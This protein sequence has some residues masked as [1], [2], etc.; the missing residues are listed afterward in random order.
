MGA[1]G[2][3]GFRDHGWRLVR[4]RH[5]PGTLRAGGSGA[6][7]VPGAETTTLATDR[8]GRPRRAGGDLGRPAVRRTVLASVG[9]DRR[10]GTRPG[11]QRSRFHVH[12][13]HHAAGPPK[14]G[15]RRTLLATYRPVPSTGRVRHRGSGRNRAGRR[16]VGTGG[17]RR[18]EA[19][20]F[21]I[22]RRTLADGRFGGTA[23]AP[24]GRVV[25]GRGG[26]GAARSERTAAAAGPG[27]TDAADRGGAARAVVRYV[28]AVA[29]GRGGTGR[30][31]R[32]RRY[33][34][35]SGGRRRVGACLR[36]GHMA[37]FR[38]NG[39]AYERSSARRTGV[40]ARRV[41]GTA[42]RTD[43]RAARTVR[44]RATVA[45]GP[46]AGPGVGTARGRTA[47]AGRTA[48]AA[49]FEATPRGFG[50]TVQVRK[51][52]DGRQ[53]EVEGVD[54]GLP[55]AAGPPLAATAE[56]TDRTG[57]GA[58]SDV[59]GLT[60]VE[61][62]VHGHGAG[63]AGARAEDGLADQGTA[64][65]RDERPAQAEGGAAD[66]T[67]DG[68]ALDGGDRVLHAPRRAVALEHL[69]ALDDRVHRHHHADAGGDGGEQAAQQHPDDQP[70]GGDQRGDGLRR[71]EGQLG[72]LERQPD[73]LDQDHVLRVLQL[74][75]G[76]PAELAELARR[77]GH[78]RH[79]GLELSDERPE[80]VRH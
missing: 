38:L 58:E 69:D 36:H 43:R 18:G 22:R 30:T 11:G 56:R 10:G 24:G 4:G 13:R 67:A 28:G 77:L 62:L 17:E 41:H 54:P 26:R 47:A 80:L 16:L 46:G 27:R 70:H 39:R 73:E 20:Q 3:G 29:A 61:E 71:P 59:L 78:V 74:H 31:H 64:E 23:L 76:V 52:G 79:V 51:V 50:G 7:T 1:A 63:R 42:R 57:R 8:R 60:A 75:P 45:P 2:L 44:G 12:R 72:D 33:G 53:V 34:L 14:R 6:G 32:A 66:R 35:G 55:A 19:R 68:A 25:R 48:G 5:V 37:V 49:G 21:G 40:T 15:G 9:S 65:L